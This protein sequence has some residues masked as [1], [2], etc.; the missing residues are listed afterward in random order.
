DG[1]L[2]PIKSTAFDP[3]GGGGGGGGGGGSAA[4]TASYHVDNDWGAGFVATV[5]VTNS[6]TT[7]TRG[8]KVTRPFGGNQSVTNSWNAPV[9]QPGASVTGT[10][11]SHNGALNAGAQTSF[12]FQATY[13]GANSSPAPTCSA[14]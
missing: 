7:A 5:T 12:G 10:N 1:Y 2:T 14:Q 11:A 9:T 3:I 13:S 8:R 4:C 6:G